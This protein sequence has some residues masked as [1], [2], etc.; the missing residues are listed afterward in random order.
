MFD[1]EVVC[2]GVTSISRDEL[3]RVFWVGELLEG[4][5][6]AYFG[7]I[8]LRTDDHMLHNLVVIVHQCLE[9]SPVLV[10]DEEV[11][12]I[13][14]NSERSRAE[15]V[16]YPH[17]RRLKAIIDCQSHRAG[18]NWWAAV[19]AA[20]TWSVRPFTTDFWARV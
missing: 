9:D 1:V 15:R 18:S 5:T 17:H 3:I 2:I 19:L 16:V 12:I 20:R 13:H 14:G 10:M 7:E 6:S 8:A 11:R 4:Y